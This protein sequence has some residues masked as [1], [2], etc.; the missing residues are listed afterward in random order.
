[1][2][3]S[4]RGF[5]ACYVFAGAEGACPLR[6]TEAEA[7]ADAAAIRANY[8]GH[9]RVW[10]ERVG[11]AGRFAERDW[12]AMGSSV[13]SFEQARA[14]NETVRAILANGGT[15]EDCVVAL[16]NQN[17]VGM[18]QLA[19]V[20]AIAPRKYRLPD[21]RVFVWRCPDDMVPEDG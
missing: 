20:Q 16:V 12:E 3:D 10:V 14:T 7:A 18:A 11:G 17:L 13:R 6:P 1:M 2:A 9:V 8:F 19:R 4:E 15:A 5:R 21:G